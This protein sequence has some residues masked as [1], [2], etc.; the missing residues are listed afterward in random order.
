MNICVYGA[1]SSVIDHYYI[2]IVEK[3]CT[4]LG[5][6]GH[7]LIFGAGDCGL[8]GAAARGIKEGNGYV[9]GVIPSFFDDEKIDV[10]G[11]PLIP[12]DPANCPGNGKGNFT[13]EDTGEP[14][15]CCCDGCEHY[16][17]C[18]KVPLWEL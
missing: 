14:V 7:N 8:M 5:S 16:F 11:V 15:E 6:H 9:L 4:E 12:G 13:Y 3:L 1:A 2:D 10:S 18:Y 17:D